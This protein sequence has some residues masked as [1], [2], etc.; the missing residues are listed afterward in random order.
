MNNV[1]TLVNIAQ[2]AADIRL[3]VQIPTTIVN[4]FRD[5]S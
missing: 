3:D 4:V 1:L 5:T 2:G